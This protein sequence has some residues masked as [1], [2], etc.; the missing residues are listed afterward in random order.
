VIRKVESI[1]PERQELILIGLEP[2]LHACVETCLPR[3]I[4]NIA[5]VLGSKGAKRWRREDFA[6]TA[7]CS[8][9]PEVGVSTI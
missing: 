1:E 2:L 6:A 9:E 3:T 7:I 5:V 4:E 8:V